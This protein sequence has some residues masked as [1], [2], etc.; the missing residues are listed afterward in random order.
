[1]PLMVEVD[2]H[3]GLS[4]AA[5]ATC[6]TAH[7][8]LRWREALPVDIDAQ[9]MV[10]IDRCDAFNR[11]NRVISPM[12]VELDIDPL[13]AAC[14]LVAAAKG[15]PR[16]RATYE[17]DVYTW[18]QEQAAALRDKHWA[19]LDLERLAEEVETWAATPLC[20]RTPAGAVAHPRV[21]ISG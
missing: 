1:M 9:W 3:Q 14:G 7:A 11:M 16:I 13:G 20:H 2:T 19:A 10:S 8:R 17:T 5:H 18:T 4:R 15:A 12:D 6:W 21:E